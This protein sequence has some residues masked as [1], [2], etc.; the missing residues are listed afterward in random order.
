[1]SSRT[2]Y[3]WAAALAIAFVC[4]I[5]G[6]VFLSFPQAAALGET[7]EWGEG[8][9]IDG[10]TIVI[11][12]AETYGTMATA[13]GKDYSYNVFDFDMTLDLTAD[14]SYAMFDM[15]VSD[16]TKGLSVEMHAGQLVLRGGTLNGG[17]YSIIPAPV[18]D[19]KETKTSRHV[20]ITID[21][22]AGLLTVIFDNDPVLKRFEIASDQEIA[23]AGALQFRVNKASLRLEN[24]RAYT[25]DMLGR[26]AEQS[27]TL[28]EHNNGAGNIVIAGNTVDYGTVVSDAGSPPTVYTESLTAD[29]YLYDITFGGLAGGDWMAYQFF[30]A[31]DGQQPLWGAPGNGAV[32]LVWTNSNAQFFYFHGAT[33]SKVKSVSASEWNLYDGNPH[34]VHVIIDD[35][36]RTAVLK[37]DG[38]VAAEI[39]FAEYVTAGLLTENDYRTSGQFSAQ[40]GQPCTI[41]LENLEFYDAYSGYA[42]YLAQEA[43]FWKTN[44]Y[45]AGNTLWEGAD[46]DNS[47]WTNVRQ[48]ASNLYYASV[49][50]A[51]NAY[52]YSYTGIAGSPVQDYSADVVRFDF[53]GTFVEGSQYFIMGFFTDTEKSYGD[54]KGY[55]F[56]M[57]TTGVTVYANETA[58]TKNQLGKIE[59]NV[60]DGKNHSF[61]L[62]RNDQTG[63][64]TIRIDAGQEFVFDIPAGLIG[65]KGGFAALANGAYANVSDFIVYQSVIPV[66]SLRLETQ[67]IYLA[68]DGT[69]TSSIVASVVPS[70]ATFPELK[71]EV[72]QGEGVVQVS[73]SGLITALKSGVG[74]VRVSSARY[75]EIFSDL[76]VHVT[77]TEVA[78]ESVGIPSE[79]TVEKGKTYTFRPV[80]T[81][82]GATYRDVVYEIVD[83]TGATVDGNGVLSASA[84]E[85]T[86]TVKVSSVRNPEITAECKIT[87]IPLQP[88]SV[89]FDFG[90]S[91]AVL[92]TGETLQIGATALP[93]E[94]EDQTFTYESAD[95]AVATVDAEGVITAVGNG[96]TVIT[97]T[98]QEQELGA[99]SALFE[100]RVVARN[101]SAEPTY[102]VSGITAENLE[103]LSDNTGKDENICS[104]SDDGKELSIKNYGEGQ[105]LI[106]SERADISADYIKF[107]LKVNM[108]SSM[109]DWAFAV[110]MRTSTPKT[111]FY[112][113][114]DGFGLLFFSTGIQLFVRQA[115]NQ[116][117]VG[118]IGASVSN[119]L[120]GDAHTYELMIDDANALLRVCIDGESVFIF[121]LPAGY[122]S[123]G[124]IQFISNSA[125]SPR[126][127][128]F[129]VRDFYA[130]EISD[131]LAPGDISFTETEKTIRRGETYQLT[132]N[133][134]SES[135]Q[136]LYSSASSS[137]TV[138]E[139]G[140]V[141]AVNIP[142]G[143][144]VI[145]AYPYGWEG[146]AAEIT[147]TV[148][149]PEA[150]GL[151]LNKE[152][153]F[154]DGG[155]VTGLIALLQPLD[156]SGMLVFE[157]EDQ[158]VATVDQSGT[159]T[160]LSPGTTRIKIS[161]QGTDISAYCNVT[162]REEAAAEVSDQTNW[163]LAI[164]VPAA[165]LVIGAAVLVV[166]K[167]KKIL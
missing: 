36:S 12:N 112:S 25:I 147:I 84:G 26:K 135:D 64:L 133:G 131:T 152:N 155:Q 114:Q 150:E 143:S 7:I 60:F 86:V 157:S 63:K 164:G 16:G 5:L 111:A 21:D 65:V 165:I 68:M 4:L 52:G 10:R 109:L 70:D 83:G 41:K 54:A 37:I 95:T 123:D 128:E 90:V 105:T 57:N 99:V 100:V 116:T 119:Y 129:V 81:P 39:S 27:F 144:V 151:S 110:W 148:L 162:V 132:L 35:A 92:E 82:E 115:G 96:S 160:A 42:D 30:R 47:L 126:P 80:F 72:I 118:N 34:S 62:Q 58:G 22:D 153:I 28:T 88:E 138:S 97:V 106:Y 59:Q 38:S 32:A 2:K 73:D 40:F 120:N 108:S 161:V 130:A 94:V 31:A 125:N 50:A 89:A 79:V 137:V 6:A 87:L 76:T 3:G 121:D 77:D 145:S 66:T 20:R 56:E 53:A 124:G 101:A 102:D 71:Y 136:I 154:L 14:D 9:T 45:V 18:L 103:F 51:D 11:D 127:T 48:T 15:R 78:L 104:V 113:A 13:E 23:S 44:Y 122:R 55:F 61:F 67:E 8:G 156:A 74:V 166:L 167:L 33:R 149:A 159:V 75:P 98:S 69:T 46:D 93:E 139:T 29:E 19:L 140:L 117:A 163:G 107:D 17:K 158:D 91:D 142:S 85:G 1:M 49:S 146:Y 24:F 141:T 134:A 43:F